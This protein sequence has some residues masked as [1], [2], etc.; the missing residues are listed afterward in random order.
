MAWTKGVRIPTNLIVGFLGSGKTTAIG[1]LINR[2]P[3]GQKWSIFINEYGMVSIDQAIVDTGTSDLAVE[4]LGGGCACCTMSYAFQ[5]LLAQFIRRSKPD[6]LIVEP[7]GASHPA[8]VID[9]LR[10][11]NFSSVI[12]LR[13]T[14]CLIDPSDFENERKRETAVF[15]DQIQVADIVIINWTDKRDRSLIDRCRCWIETF[16]P[17]K[18]LILESSFG[19]IDP[20][21]LDVDASL[22]RSATFPDAHS[23]LATILGDVPMLDVVNTSDESSISA[24]LAKP[25]VPLRLANNDKEHDA[26]GWVF[27]VDD[28]FVR[29]R[30]FELLESIQ[31]IARLKGIFRCEDGW[32]SINRAKDTTSRSASVYRRDS[33]LEIILDQPSISWLELERRILDCLLS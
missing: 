2:R 3:A 4:E 6:R 22:V 13:N 29:E 11:P 9:M 20:A 17:P 33:R 23:K 32:W 19:E 14:I 10:S 27:H 21:C 30:I 25:G 5:P 16:A 18:L 26:C 31:P 24:N 12:D 7:S 15:H 8:N 1:K 28:I